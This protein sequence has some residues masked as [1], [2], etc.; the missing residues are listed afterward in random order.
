MLHKFNRHNPVILVPHPDL[1]TEEAEDLGM[2]VVGGY[3]SVNGE[4]T[5]EEWHLWPYS[6]ATLEE[7][8]KELAYIRLWNKPGGATTEELKA[9]DA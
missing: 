3:P 2:A 6:T 9:F 1:S 7:F 5:G 8:E 4:W